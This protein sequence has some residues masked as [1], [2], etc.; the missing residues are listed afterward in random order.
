M[1]LSLTTVCSWGRS[2]SEVR[3][4]L[5]QTAITLAMTSASVRP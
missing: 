4:S 2:A 1:S 5:R 3:D